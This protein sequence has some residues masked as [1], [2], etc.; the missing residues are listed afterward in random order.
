MSEQEQKA[1]LAELN[2]ELIR[3]RSRCEVWDAV[4]QALLASSLLVIAFNVV[5]YKRNIQGIYD[6]MI[7]YTVL[8]TVACF[9]LA[10]LTASFRRRCE[11]PV[12]R[13][14]LEQSTIREMYESRNE[15]LPFPELRWEEIKPKRLKPALLFLLVLLCAAG[16]CAKGWH[17]ADGLLERRRRESLDEGWRLVQAES[18]KS[19]SEALSFAMECDD[20]AAEEVNALCGAMSILKSGNTWQ[21]IYEL[22][23]LRDKARTEAVREEAKKNLNAALKPCYDDGIRALNQGDALLAMQ[24][25]TETDKENYRESEPFLAYSRAM[26]ACGDDHYYMAKEYCRQGQ[27]ASES[28]DMQRFGRDMMDYILQCE[29]IWETKQA[30]VEKA[31]TSQQKSTQQSSSSSKKKSSGSSSSSSKQ[32]SKDPYDA[33][34]YYHPEDL[35]DWYEDDFWDYEDAEDYWDEYN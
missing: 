16:F 22:R 20:P 34:S 31:K 12:S 7:G 32:S 21:G 26:N 2:Q 9:L 18:W 27:A 14:Q 13:I 28:K 15:T 4:T 17:D 8:A 35:Y 33:K 24:C 29:R 30:E 25:F 5:L 10:A 23:E 19:A 11:K 3:L 1:T 6:S